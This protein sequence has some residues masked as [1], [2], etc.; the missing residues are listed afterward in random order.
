MSSL[1]HDLGYVRVSLPLLSNYL[2][3]KDIYWSLGVNPP[4]RDAGYPQLTLGGIM[5][6]LARLEAR[7]A[8][9]AQKHEIQII[10]NNLERIKVKWK[11]AWQRKAVREFGARLK[12]WVNFLEDVR[13]NPQNHCDRYSYEV[14]RRVM[15][16]LLERDVGDLPAS[17]IE[18]LHGID[19]LLRAVFIQNG[20]IWEKEIER[21]FPRDPYWFLYGRIRG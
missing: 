10:E 8:S 7:E 17:D 20:F 4:I 2:L 18:L 3:S 11:V 12:L 15:L 13:D 21:G 1:N 9:L 5:L 6:A 16:H 14:S 19:E